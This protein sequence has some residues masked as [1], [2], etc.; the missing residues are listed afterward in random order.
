MKTPF[1]FQ[2]KDI[3]FALARTHVL[4]ASECGIG[5]TVEA[6][7]VVHREWAKGDEGPVLVLCNRKA[8]K[9][10]A[11]MIREQWDEAPIYITG[12]AGRWPKEANGVKL[13][14]LFHP[15][16]KAWVIAHHEALSLPRRKEAREA[17]SFKAPEVWSQ[18]VW[19]RIIVDE[20][21]R[22]KSRK[23]V[24]THQL[25]ALDGIKRMGLSGTP[26]DSN[27]AQ[28]WTML[29]WMYPQVF[30]SYWDF[31]KFY[32]GWDDK[33][34]NLKHLARLLS[35]F[36][37]RRMKND[38]DVA[39]DLPPRIDQYVGVDMPEDSVQSFLYRKIADATDFEIKFDPNSPQWQMVVPNVLAKI[40]RL[41]Q[42]L[43]DPRLIGQ[44][45]ETCKLDYVREWLEDNPTQQVVVF[46]R[47]RDT[48][49]RLADEFKGACVIGGRE[50]GYE[51]WQ[52]GKLRLL[53]GT[54]A[55]MG[56]KSVV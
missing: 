34:R 10:W 50:D 2:E 39:P 15:R 42:V 49:Q 38:P 24:R 32:T 9:Q 19:Q 55:S 7:E 4:N 23:S 17:R 27:P 51:D 37:I 52:A 16:H 22:Y 5:K 54:I 25:R 1:P 48:A 53:F 21:H 46:T 47:F 12:K 44:S 26:I 3:E 29:N 40:T 8:K 11:D 36:T 13:H 43:N 35:E 56:G 30:P 14:D 31:Q 41:Q 6:I 28:F 18:Y 20:C 45:A 33:P